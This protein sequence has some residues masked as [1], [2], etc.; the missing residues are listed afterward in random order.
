MICTRW[1]KKKNLVAFSF[2]NRAEGK[3][4]RCCKECHSLYGK[5]WYQKNSEK[6]KYAVAERRKTNYK[7]I[8]TYIVNYLKDHPCVGCGEADP[9]VLE[10]D[11]VRGKKRYSV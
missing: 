3:R 6:Q 4:S 1:Q 11:H 10:F 9:I 2:K 8:R 7:P 5:A